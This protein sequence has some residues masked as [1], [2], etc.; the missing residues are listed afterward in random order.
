MKKI[1]FLAAILFI[2]SCKTV[3]LT[4][5][6]Q[7]NLVPSSEM[8]SLSSQQYSQV[9]QESQVITNTA[10]SQM[11]KNVG[12]RIKDAVERY[13]RENNKSELIDGYNWEFNLIKNDTIVNAWCMPGGK[14]A[15]Y[16]GILPICMDEQG[17]AVVMGHEVSHAIARH[18]NE[19]MSQGLLQEY[20]GIALSVALSQKSEQTQQ[21]FLAAY[22]LGTQYGNLLPYSRTQESEADH[23][24]LI[25]MAMAGYD[26]H[27]AISFWQRMDAQAG[28]APPEFLSTHPSNATRIKNLNK[29]MDEAMKYYSGSKN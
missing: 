9:L 6:S 16:T 22:G 24:G 14:V 23:L 10:Q 8:Q 13:L 20:G 21:L 11:V 12:M 25:F 19:R 18:G 3:P 27:E 1:F 4:G 26:P 15:F 29:W 7:L 17:I 5:R 2:G 28:A